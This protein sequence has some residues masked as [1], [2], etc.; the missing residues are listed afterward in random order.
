MDRVI[1]TNGFENVER[2]KDAFQLFNELS[3]SL[4]DSYRELENQVARLKDELAATRSERLRTLIEK[5]LLAN[6]LQQLL[7]ALP[8][9]VLVLDGEGGAIEKNGVAGKLLG[10][11]LLGLRWAE[12]AERCFLPDSDNPHERR[13]RS[14]G[15]VSLSHSSAGEEAGQIILLTDVSEMRALQEMVNRHK[16]LTA[17]GEMV[18]A[19]AHQV[20]TPLSAAVLYAS[21]LSK[22][23]LLEDRRLR[24]AQ[25]LRERLQH[26][27]RQVNDMLIFA[28]GGRLGM[29]AF[30]LEGLLKKVADSMETYAYGET[31]HFEII[32]RTRIGTVAGNEDALLGILMNLLS[33][34]VEA[35]NG[36]GALK[37]IVSEPRRGVVRFSVADDGP[38]I[39]DAHRE[40]IF[41]PFFT[42]RSN[43]TGLGLAVVE[44][45]VRAHGGSIRCESPPRQGAVFHIT[46][47]LKQGEAQPPAGFFVRRQERRI[48]RL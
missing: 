43:G 39:S 22:A 45:V 9:G 1:K 5:E 14:G 10:E 8:G 31:V 19:M 27:E 3:R 2:L 15:Y 44:A 46:I 7:E 42:T 29:A 48:D 38:G 13:L 30:P 34:A 16:R 35:M 18:A 25:K 4:T 11:P 24:F 17:M 37:L 12:I 41:E 26:L 6:R 20:R 32:N 36:S 33:N 23:G 47:P 40:R 21:H 28:R